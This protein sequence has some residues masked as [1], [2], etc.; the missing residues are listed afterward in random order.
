MV[1]GDDPRQAQDAGRQG[2]IRSRLGELGAGRELGGPEEGAAGDDRVTDAVGAEPPSH[3]RGRHARGGIALAVVAAVEDGERDHV[4]DLLA[5][6]AASEH[7]LGQ[8][9]LVVQ[10]D[11]DLVRS[12]RPPLGRDDRQGHEAGALEPNVELSHPLYAEEVPQQRIHRH[13]MS[14][15]QVTNPV[16]G[17]AVGVLENGVCRVLV[18]GVA[19]TA[20][21]GKEVYERLV[22]GVGEVVV[23][24]VSVT[25][26]TLSRRRRGDSPPLPLEQVT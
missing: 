6:L 20:V 13:R 24:T 21:A 18:D 26:V 9:V 14:Y 12:V 4:L 2:R 1:A 25:S 8:L 19:E 22:E 23:T 7:G 17:A 16:S 10:A 15:Q 3:G 11:V 5:E